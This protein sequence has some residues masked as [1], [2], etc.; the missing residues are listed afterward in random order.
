MTD[1]PQRHDALRTVIAAL[2]QHGLAPT[3]GGSGLLLAHGLTS[4][5]GDWDV[6]VDA[7]PEAV[8]A[9]LDEEGLTWVDADERGDRYATEERLLVEVNGV[10]VDVMV[11]FAIWPGG[12]ESGNAAVRIPSL[13][14]GA[15]SDTPLG[16]LEAWLVAYR[17]MEREG[18][19]EAIVA[20]L[21]EHGANPL[22]VQRML[23]EPLPEELRVELESLLSSQ[24]QRH[25]D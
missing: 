8:T 6:L 1:E 22:H 18:K 13:A 25:G 19:P 14:S 12:R 7:E 21:E 2:E 15:W 10:E 4:E 17:L 11:G 3:L 5:A 20:H 9:A 16:S 24:V 23:A